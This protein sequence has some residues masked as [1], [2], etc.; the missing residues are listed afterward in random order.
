MRSLAWVILLAAG[1]A[2]PPV[3][4]PQPMAGPQETPA[5]SPPQPGPDD[6]YVLDPSFSR[7]TAHVGSAGLL[8][9]F[10][11]DHAV[12]LRD[13]TGEL[14]FPGQDPERASIQIMV[15]AASAAETAKGFREAERKKIDA[16]VHKKALEVSKFPQIVFR[17]TRIGARESREG[18]LRVEIRGDLTL[19][20]VTRPVVIPAR[21]TLDGASITAQGEFT[22]R[23]GDY[24]LRRLS[25]AGGTVKASEE[26]RMKFE[27]VARK[28]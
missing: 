10:G 8:S 5:P 13:L 16:D 28:P 15:R 3:E 1:C 23:H 18:L 12:A 25:A 6:L 17:S 7:V 24:G 2:D 14:R 21:V 19:H 9:G 20:G 4:T 26:I 11:H 27:I 22:I